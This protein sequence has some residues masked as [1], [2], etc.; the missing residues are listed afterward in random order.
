MNEEEKKEEERLAKEAADKVAAEE[1]AKIEADKKAAEEA[2]KKEEE[3]E[4]EEEGEDPYDKEMRLMREAKEK[5]DEI[6]RQKSGALEEERK[7]RGAVE[8][9]LAKLEAKIEAGL[10]TIDEEK[11]VAKLRAEISVSEEI[12]SLTSNPKEQALIKAYM[13]EKNLS[14]EDAYILANKHIVREYKQKELE[15]DGEEI[16]LAR[17][18][19]GGAGNGGQPRKSAILKAAEDGLSESERKHLEADEE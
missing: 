7:K 3:E 6:A 18:S 14:A 2:A 8:Q 4:E 11:I 9:R 12:K 10:G 5:S 17:L 15:S 13:A 1:A 19:G 16:V